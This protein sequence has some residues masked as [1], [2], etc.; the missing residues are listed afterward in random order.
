MKKSRREF[1]K[2]H[3]GVTDDP[4]LLAEE[5]SLARMELDVTLESDKRRWPS[6][7]FERFV[8]AVMRYAE[9]MD[10]SKLIHRSV[11]ADVSGA[12]E[13]LE[14]QGRRVPGSALAEA[15]RLEVI[16]FNGYDPHFEGPEPPG[17]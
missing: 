15:D 14:L 11:G 3:D 4:D 16:L 7:S 2:G 17:L 8:N 5:V 10:G 9:V 13:Y 1:F 6:D 12:R